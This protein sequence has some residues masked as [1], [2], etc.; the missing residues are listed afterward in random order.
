MLWRIRKLGLGEMGHA[1]SFCSRIKTVFST[2]LHLSRDLKCL[3]RNQSI[4]DGGMCW[5]WEARGRFWEMS[6]HIPHATTLC[7]VARNNIG[8]ENMDLWIMSLNQESGK[9]FFVHCVSLNLTLQI[10]WWLRLSTWNFGW[11]CLVPWDYVGVWI[12]AVLVPIVVWSSD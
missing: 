8:P 7:S 9:Y 3:R 4:E 6:V 11:P 10:S 5:G 2:K 12:Y 1:W